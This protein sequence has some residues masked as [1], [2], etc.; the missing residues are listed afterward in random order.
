MGIDYKVKPPELVQL[1]DRGQ[2]T[3]P[4]ALRRELGVKDGDVF[5]V[6]LL[7]DSLVVT[8]KRLIAPDVARKIERLMAVQG[9]TLDDLLAGIEVEREAGWEA[10]GQAA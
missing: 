5:S 7:G 8:K 4:A 2:L 3:I 10:H 1:R 9:L 6:M